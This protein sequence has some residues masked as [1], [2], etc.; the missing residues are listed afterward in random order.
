MSETQKVLQDTFKYILNGDVAEEQPEAEEATP[1]TEE[2]EVV[3]APPIGTKDTETRSEKP[4]YITLSNEGSLL[5]YQIET[6]EVTDPAA[7]T[8]LLQKQRDI[9]IALINEVSAKYDEP[10]RIA[11][12][13]ERV[14]A[15]YD[16][17][18]N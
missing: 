13:I 16:A 3:P 5:E 4:P 9:S 1:N 10:E 11:A 2:M 6:G 18:I 17:L 14:N 8:Q 12:S 15:K 7:V